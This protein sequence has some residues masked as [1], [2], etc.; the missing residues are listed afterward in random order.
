MT[1]TLDDAQRA[2]DDAVLRAVIRETRAARR[3]RLVRSGALIALAI[4]FAAFSPVAAWRWWLV[5]AMALAG[6]IA[7]GRLVRTLGPLPPGELSIFDGHHALTHVTFSGPWLVY[8]TLGAR[9]VLL[10]G[11][12]ARGAEF[13]QVLR[14]RFPDVRQ[15]VSI[16]P[17]GPPDVPRA[18]ALPP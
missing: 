15:P 1:A 7:L 16:L 14:R 3:A 11:A 10:I 13:R 12:T 18:T 6:A 9:R 17:P 4:G 2:A 5:G 8:T